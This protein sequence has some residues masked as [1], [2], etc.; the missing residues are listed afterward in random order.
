MTTTVEEMKAKTEVALN[1]SQAVAVKSKADEIVEL[2]QSQKD[3]FDE[4]LQKSI[5]KER[6]VRI[7]LSAFRNTP[8]LMECSKVSLV[9]ALMNSAALGLEPNTPLG[10]SYLIPRNSRD[11]MQVRF[12]IGY[13]GLLDLARR[14][15]QIVTIHADVVRAEDFYEAW[16]GSQAHLKH[17]PFRAG[18]RGAVVT[19]YAY[20]KL[21]D[22]GFQFVE[23]PPLDIEAIRQRSQAKDS[24]P[25]VTDYEAMAKKTVLKQ[26][27]KLLPQSV[28]ISHALQADIDPME[29]V[30]DEE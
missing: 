5:T 9:N 10:L 24:G 17:V 30:N 27:C 2:M 21:K 13:K 4:V 15:G 23:M 12:E 14:S 20:A 22:G 25:W 1:T 18:D 6:F 11:G 26:L 3:A 28:H 7:A 8:K 16:H 29:P 19:Y